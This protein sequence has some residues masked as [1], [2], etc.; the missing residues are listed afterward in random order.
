MTNLVTNL[1]GKLLNHIKTAEE[2]WVAVALMNLDGFNFISD[3]LKSNC[4]QNYLIGVDL[5]TDPKA[6]KILNK[7]QLNSDTNIRLY[8]GKEF[9]HPKL[10]L[11]QKK[12]S[13]NA[14]IGSAN[15]TNGGLFNNVELTIH[16]S[17]RTTCEQLKKWF[18]K[19]FNVGKPLT[20]KF[21]EQ[22]QA[23]YLERQARKKQDTKIARQEKKI[24][25]NEFEATLSEKNDFIKVLKSYRNSTDYQ[26]VV[27]ERKQAIKELRK[28]IDYPNFNKINVDDFF[29]IWA[30]GHLIAIAIP[31]IKRQIPELKQLLKWLC[32]EKVDIALRYDKALTGN[33]KVEGVSKAFVSKILI[34][35]R[36]DIYF[37]KNDKSEKALRKYGIQLPRGLT[38]GDKYKI[39]CKFLQQICKDT[40][41][42]DLSVLDEYLYLEGSDNE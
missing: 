21:I 33:F 20:T 26:K 2:I 17:E 36:P 7:K 3:N 24:L 25:N 12:N 42:K 39:T 14:Y 40:N 10:Y 1:S 35:H 38:V 41:I 37:V 8:A 13:Y 6:L 28:A 18:T 27:E 22:Y 31:A 34:A 16:I 19:F 4:R 11:I 23:D 15:C 9:F 30:L 29:S 32:N 5:P